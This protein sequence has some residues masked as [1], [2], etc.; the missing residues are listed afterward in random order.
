M[1]LISVEAQQEN[2]KFSKIL[3]AIDGSAPS[4]KAAEFAITMAEKERNEQLK[5]VEAN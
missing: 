5:K 4:M 1:C 2:G 3:V